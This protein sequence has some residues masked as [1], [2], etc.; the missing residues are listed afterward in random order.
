[1]RGQQRKE[2]RTGECRA[3]SPLL[4]AVTGL[5]LSAPVRWSMILKFAFLRAQKRGFRALKMHTSNRCSQLD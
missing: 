4:K 2:G 5:K 3:T 1:M